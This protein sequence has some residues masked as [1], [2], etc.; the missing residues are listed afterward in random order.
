MMYEISLKGLRLPIPNL[1]YATSCIAVKNH[2]IAS[3][4]ELLYSQF[5]CSVL[6]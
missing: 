4:L 6:F 5:F 2:E 1:F 3:L